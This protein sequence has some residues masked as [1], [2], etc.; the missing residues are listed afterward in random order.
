V[1]WAVAIGQ[2]TG[3]TA[4]AVAGQV[5]CGVAATRSGS[6]KTALGCGLFAAVGGLSRDYGPA[7]GICGLLVLAETATGRRLLPAFL[8]G[9]AVALPWM[10][11]NWWHTG[12][13]VYSNPTPLG[14][15][16][17]PVHAALMATYADVFSVFACDRGDVVNLVA[18]LTI[19]AGAV[20]LLGLAGAGFAG[21]AGIPL[22]ATAALTAGLWAWST[23]FTAGGL[24]Y[25]LRVL[26]PTMVSLALLATAATGVWRHVPAGLRTW[27]RRVGGAVAVLTGGLAAVAA[28]VFPLDVAILPQSGGLA[29]IPARLLHRRADPLDD[30]GRVK[31]L[32]QTLEG[33]SIPDCRILTDNAYLAVVLRHSDSRFQPVMVWSPEVRFL[34]DGAAG[35]D[36]GQDPVAEARRELAERRIFLAMIPTDFVHWRVLGQVPFFRVDEPTWRPAVSLDGD[37]PDAGIRVMPN[38]CR[39]AEP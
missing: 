37:R 28:A 32:A 34:F 38:V 20:I 33:S 17:N 36:A 35:L 39:A 24:S 14:L 19:M 15:P 9:A 1:I 22:V 5:L 25:S 11:R 18:S 21:R 27:L 12:N 10:A 13:P 23:G 30:Q 8:A 29:A 2:E 26:A 7:L 3:Y 4:L 16:S 31:A 6:W